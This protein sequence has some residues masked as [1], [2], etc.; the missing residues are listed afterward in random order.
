MISPLAALS[1]AGG[2]T[3]LFMGGDLLVRG[4]IS[5]ARK[6]RIPPAIIGATVVA[7]GT[8]LPELVVSLLAAST[9]HGGVALGNVVGS[10]IANVL[11][12]L[13]VPALISPIVVEDSSMRVHCGFMIAA[14]VVFVGLCFLSPLTLWHGLVLLGVLVLA[15]V[16]TVTG[17]LSLI[18]LSAEE[19]QYERTLGLPER[20]VF[21]GLF[22]LL[23]AVF[24]PL[25]AD[26][27]LDGVTELALV[28]GVPE[29]AIAASV[30]ALGTSL[31]ELSVSVLA[32]LHKQLDM[33]IGNVVGSNALN[34]LFVIGVT[35]SITP[36]PVPATLLR[37]DLW[38]MLGFALLLTLFVFRSWR[39]GRRVGA[40]LVMAYA[41][42]IWTIF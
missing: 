1:I 34:L 3:Y 27:T 13:G 28:A 22:I 41:L 16:L 6:F 19:E 17:R 4:S 37:F 33:A 21:A 36:I 8:S 10:N 18:D 26:L 30:V 24:L 14:S 5:V 15:V 23:G 42:Y 32:A 11:V 9:G 20:P 7:L 35:A 2:L 31:P 39:I 25:G 38:V 12:V 29:T 40:G